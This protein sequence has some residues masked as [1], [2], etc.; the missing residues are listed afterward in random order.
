[1][2]TVNFAY[3]NILVAVDTEG[4]EFY[5]YNVLKENIGSDLELKV[6][7]RSIDEAENGPRSYPG[8]IVWCLAIENSE[9]YGYK[10]LKVVVRDGYYGG[11]NIDYKVEEHPDAWLIDEKRGTKT[12]DKK[13]EVLCRKVERIIKRY[14]TEYKTVGRFSD[15]TAVYKKA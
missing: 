14:G 10:E 12:L 9:G 4:W 2:G 15:G 1:M 7:G 3:D 5:E 11:I 6:G 8:T 13:V